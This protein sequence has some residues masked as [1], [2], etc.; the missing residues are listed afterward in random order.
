M[1]NTIHREMD[2][3][4]EAITYVDKGPGMIRKKNFN[5]H[6]FKHDKAVCINTGVQALGSG[7]SPS[8]PFPSPIA[9]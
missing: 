1:H 4:T 5:T 8:P 2:K 9:H 7:F 6:A 3:G